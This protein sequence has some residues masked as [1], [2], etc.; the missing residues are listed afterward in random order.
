MSDTLKIFLLFGLVCYFFVVFYFLKKQLLTLKYTLIW[1]LTGV[2]LSVFVFMPEL[3]TWITHVLGIEL[4]VNGLFTIGIAFVVM[5]LMSLTVI[6][7]G[8]SRK[9]RILV[10]KIAILEKRILELEAKERS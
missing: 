2:V 6:V 4:P 10:Q 7:S 1:I 9:I 5:I 8:Q 3:L